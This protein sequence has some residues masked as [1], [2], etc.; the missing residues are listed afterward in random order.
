MKEPTHNESSSLDMHADEAAAI[1]YMHKHLLPLVEY[2]AFAIHENWLAVFRPAYAAGCCF[3]YNVYWP[4]EIR[5]E[6]I[7]KLQDRN[8]RLPVEVTAEANP[9][10][11]DPRPKDFAARI[12]QSAAQRI[13]RASRMQAVF[14]KE[15]FLRQ[16]KAVFDTLQTEFDR[17]GKADIIRVEAVAP[18]EAILAA[19]MAIIL[20]EDLPDRTL[21]VY[22]E[23]H[24][25]ALLKRAR[26]CAGHLFVADL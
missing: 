6:T 17:L 4:D 20:L 12:A 16:A 8:I 14:R 23:D 2:T 15:A 11:N 25:P 5:K 19:Y 1:A 24:Y 21:A 10:Q 22:L 9:S 18:S 26:R 7:S 13:E 3:P